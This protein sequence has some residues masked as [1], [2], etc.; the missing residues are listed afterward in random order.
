MRYIIGFTVL[1]LI[2]IVSAGAQVT[3]DLQENTA[4]QD[5]L[6]MKAPVLDSALVGVSVFY[7]LGTK[8]SPYAGNVVINQPSYMADAFS[9]Y[10]SG[11]TGRKKQGYRIRI[12]F[13]NRQSA[14]GES[15]NIVKSFYGNFPQTPAYRSYT[16]PYFK[17]AVGDYRTKSDAI[18]A[19]NSI[20]V[21]YPKAVIIKEQI[22]YPAL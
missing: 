8:A 5:T 15:E 4:Q 3:H 22:E 12:F 19:L 16:T 17:V 14:R 7:L 20:K 11:N 1:F 18:K 6:F 2:G 10:I 13:D 9:H 21:F